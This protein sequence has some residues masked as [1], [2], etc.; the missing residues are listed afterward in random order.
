MYQGYELWF[1]DFMN[2]WNT[3]HNPP[4]SE[5]RFELIAFELNSV[6]GA[7]LPILG[8]CIQFNFGS[9]SQSPRSGDQ[10]TGSPYNALMVSGVGAAE[11]LKIYSTSVWERGRLIDCAWG[12]ILFVVVSS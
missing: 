9:Q 10:E 2:L 1:D 4:W 3:Y 8:V 12:N 7:M 11:Q 5:V 6:V